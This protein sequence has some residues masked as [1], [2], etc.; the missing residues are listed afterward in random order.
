MP[1]GTRRRGR[2]LWSIVT[3]RDCKSDSRR[4]LEV[5]CHGDGPDGSA[6]GG[7]WPQPGPPTGRPGARAAP[8]PGR[9]EILVVKMAGVEKKIEVQILRDLMHASCFEIEDDLLEAILKRSDFDLDEAVARLS[10]MGF[11]LSTQD[12][13]DDV[14]LTRELSEDEERKKETYTA[15]LND[16]EFRSRAVKFQHAAG[17]NPR[18]YVRLFLPIQKGYGGAIVGAKYKYTNKILKS[19]RE[20]MPN[21][22]PREHLVIRFLEDAVLE[23]LGITDVSCLVIEGVDQDQTERTQEL[24][25]DHIAKILQTYQDRPAP[26][27]AA[28]ANS[29]STG[30]ASLGT[31]RQTDIRGL[32]ALHVEEMRHIFIDNSNLVIGAQNRNGSFEP[33][34]RINVNELARL[35]A[36]GT[37]GRELPGSRVVAGSRA[38]ASEASAGLWDRW[39]ASGYRTDVSL[40]AHGV[41]EQHVDE[42]IHAQVRIL[43]A[44]MWP[45]LPCSSQL[46]GGNCCPNSPAAA[47]ATKVAAVVAGVRLLSVAH[48]GPAGQA[49]CGARDR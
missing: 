38:M 4:F 33:G 48:D 42:F 41:G 3:G 35:L 23:S 25:L 39:E 16:N 30:T 6:G 2:P 9:L 45:S 27:V 1:V 31:L 29:P 5:Q 18:Q 40:R 36:T 43:S 21:V 46:F 20:M 8:R 12:V 13:D 22:S 44:L 7:Q 19:A 11:N 15:S 14:L 10:E 24:L 17:P 37:C 49:H 28:T 26:H 32:H 47:V 34:V